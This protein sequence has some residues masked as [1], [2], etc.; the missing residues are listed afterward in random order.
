[1]EKQV[2]VA[3][4]GAGT[5]GL[6]VMG[7]VRRAGKSF[8]MINGGHTG[9][10]CARVGCM[11]SKAL[12]QVADDYYR[13]KMFPRFGIDGSE[14]LKPDLPEVMEYVREIR[15]TLVDRVLGGSIDTLDDETFIDGYAE[16]IDANTLK[17][18]DMTVTAENIVIATGSTPIIPD[19]WQAFGDRIITTDTF[20]EEETLPQ[21]VAV[22]GLGVIGLELGQAMA[23]LGVKVTGVDMTEIL[24]GLSD[25]DINQQA[26]DILGRE[27]DLWQ[28]A[29]AELEEADGKIRVRAG[30]NEIV[31]DKVL[32][33]MGRRPNLDK[34]KLE[35]L[36][37]ALDAQGV[38]EYDRTTQ[39]IGDLNVYIIGDADNE[40]PILHEAADDGKIA[41]FNILAGESVPFKRK[42]PLAITFTDPN[43]IQVGA[44]WKDLDQD[45]LVV[46]QIPMG[47]VGRALT[48][49]KNR[50]L[51]KIYAEKHSGK[52]LGGAMIGVCGENIAH[53]LAWSVQQEKTV[54]DLLRMP[55]YH[56]VMEEALQGALRN[57][58][59]KLEMDLPSHVEMERLKA[60]SYICEV[61]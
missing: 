20:F 41:A 52:L 10:T 61:A 53:L 34:L 45:N 5:A 38:P 22:I 21:N 32:A 42:T 14:A 57:A 50:G 58:L 37:V 39:R 55:F 36:G 2:E 30:E 29:P 26:K 44:C 33:A 7:R 28:G 25:P 56:P 9:T 4:I 43:I 3:I 13:R 15:D 46:G 49:A 27:F 6:N 54:V 17:V 48:K 35:N 1:M 11:P 16:F 19:A 59:G 60:Q 24:S 51:L 23:R 18:N 47:P 31:V 8:V 40:K 12:I